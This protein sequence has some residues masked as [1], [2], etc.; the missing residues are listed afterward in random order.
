MDAIIEQV[1]IFIGASILLV[2]LFHK[3][4]FGSVLGY[5]IA[6][7]FVGPYGMGLIHDLESVMHFAEIGVILL[8]FVIGLEI[9]P[10]RLWSMK[11]DLICLGGLQ[12]LL[13]TAVFTGIG[14]MLGQ[15]LVTAA[16]LSFGMSLSSTAFAIQSLTAKNNFNTEFGKSSFSIL[17][18]QDLLAIPAL[19]IIPNFGTGS[20]TAQ[21]WPNLTWLF[22]LFLV[23]LILIS[24]FLIQPFFRIIARMNQREIFTAT[25]LFIVMSVAMIM[26]KIGLSAALGTFIAGVLLA[27]SEYRHELE[28]N[29]EPFK[30]LL[31]GLFFISVGMTVSLPLILSKPLLVFGFALIYLL[32]KGSIIYGTGRLFKLSHYNAKMMSLTIAQ[33]GEFAFVIFGLA[34]ASKIVDE[35]TL[36]LLTA[37]ITLSMA[38]NPLLVLIDEK[39]QRRQGVFVEPNY[40][41]IKGEAPEVI[42]AGFG[43]FGQMFGR[44]LKAQD[45][46]FVAIDHDADQVELL[47]KFGNKV[48][49]GDVLRTDLLEAAG[50]R[51]AKYFVLAVDDAEVS[52]K[53]AQMIR[54]NFPNVEIFARSRNRGHSFD[55][56]DAGIKHIKRETFDSSINFAGDLLIAM[57][58]PREKV[59]VIIEKFKIH[60]QNM[61]LEQYKVRD[62]DD[63]FVSKTKQ[64]VAQLSNVLSDESAQSYIG[65]PDKEV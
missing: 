47:R 41:E 28:A 23:A 2:P 39:I 22:P 43:R 9:Q 25:A 16:V 56:L 53:A 33:G 35:Q 4:G 17:L 5:L 20:T 26:L 60:D 63:M 62:D 45:I 12:I 64:A 37:I 27:D 55:L 38:I 7:L 34:L 46:P 50:V 10:R 18:M 29:L 61:L 3:L 44:I 8:L 57:G 21:N 13:T 59:R 1:L 36:Q 30:S 6:G 40:D 52:V 65:K 54:T 49:Y 14:M 11:K 31:L 48:Y 15:N 58:Q 51:K 19:A 42:I 32:I 24:R